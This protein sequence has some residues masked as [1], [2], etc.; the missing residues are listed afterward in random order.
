MENQMA[1]NNPYAAYSDTKLYQDATGKGA[2]IAE[3]IA[4]PKKAVIP[5]YGRPLAQQGQ[6]ALKDDVDHTEQQQEVD[7]LASLFDGEELSEE[8]K[9]KAKTI[10]E[11]AINEKVSII[12]Q[13]IILASKEII[14]EQIEARQ[15]NL[16]EH[17]DNYLNYVITEWMEENKVA[18]ERGLR[19]EIA[20]NFM[21]GLK[22]LFESSFIDVPE[23]KYN[24]LDD[25]YAANEE[26]QENANALIKENIQLKNEITA[27]LCA[28]AFVEEASGLADTQ[29]EKLA[30]LAEGIEFA[31][32]NQYRQKVSLLKESYFGQKKVEHQE[33]S[34]N[35]VTLT[36]DAGSFVSSSQTEP[37]PIMENIVNAITM[38]NKNRPSKPAFKSMNDSAVV[39]RIQS[40]MNPMLKDK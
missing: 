15:S 28:E 18:I 7:Y 19:T 1:E 37:N 21:M 14:E 5:Q 26:L 16:V 34:T 33:Q 8:F 29:V 4:D 2:K 6:Q 25:L 13:N 17:V 9:E 3:P 20:E 40:I 22:D 27:R 24:I 31:D 10:F 23:E 39:D 38:I 32:V 36:E 11:A 30:K 12:E 35:Q